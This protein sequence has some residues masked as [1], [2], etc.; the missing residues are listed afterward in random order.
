MAGDAG[1]FVHLRVRSAYSL[2]EGAIKAEAVAHL[3]KADAMPAVALTDRANLFGALEFSVL[4]K[5]TGV[6]PIIGC[7]LP[8]KGIGEGPPER[9]ARIPTVILLAQNETGYLNLCELSSAA[10]LEVDATDAPNVA[11]SKVEAHSDGL[12][13]LSGGPDGP[14]DPLFTAGRTAEGDATLARMAAAF[15][16]RFYVELQRHGL[17]A[18]AAA[19]PGLDQWSTSFL[20]TARFLRCTVPA[21]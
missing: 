4:T 3:A 13:L 20:G 10:F 18:E 17:G 6:Q 21:S 2:L 19:E 5:D 9:W 14:V 8:V 15:G 7:A 16:D 11:W 1:G 12:I